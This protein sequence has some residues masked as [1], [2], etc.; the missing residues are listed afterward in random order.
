MELIQKTCKEFAEILASKQAVP[1]GGAAAALTGALGVALASMVANFSIGKKT[2]IGVEEKHKEILERGEELR[3]RLLDLIDEDAKNFYPLSKAYGIKATTEKEKEAKQETLQSALKIA[4]SAPIKMVDAIYES[5]LLHEELFDISS[6][7]IISDLG[8]GVQCL[9]A[10]LLGAELNVIINLNSI[11]DEVY[12]AEIKEHVDGLV[13]K[14]SQKA[15]D[16]YGKVIGK[17]NE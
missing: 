16:I 9:K 1:G 4:C 15:D 11:K 13:N 8:V 7:L 17:M 10:A 14:G 2:F 12:K 3:E 6:K 5:I